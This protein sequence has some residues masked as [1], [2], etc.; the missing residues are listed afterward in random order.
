MMRG[1]PSIVVTRPK[2]AALKLALPPT[3]RQ[4]GA[5]DAP[6]ERVEQIERLEP[7]LQVL[8]R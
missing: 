1:E 8:G 2:V 7:Q 3:S 5:G 6:V 4:L